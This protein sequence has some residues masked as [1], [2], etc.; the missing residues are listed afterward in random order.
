[1]K[2]SVVVPAFNEERL[3]AQSL[4]AINRARAAFDIAG[5]TSELI[6][7][8]N[9]STDR[10]AE[11]ARTAGATVVFEP[12]NQ[13]GRA[14][15]TGAAA[16]SGE[17]L[18]F[19]DADSQPSPELFADVAEQ[20][21]SGRCVAGGC[22]LRLEGNHRLANFVTR[23]WNWKSRQRRWLAG[24]FIFVEAAAFRTLGGFDAEFFVGEELDL[25]RRLH[26]FARDS[27]REIVILHRHP[28]LTSDRKVRLYSMKELAGFTFRAVLRRERVMRD[29]SA[30][31][32]WYDGR[33]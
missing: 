28:L 3:L 30:C 17:W 23:V 1:M 25:T 20:I 11:I 24:S 19:I 29:K 12:V 9:N 18:L 15:N 22:T 2:I 26:A 6:V 32:A 8:D 16:A 31:Y 4:A 27:K 33:R 13:I 14:R 5:Y 10:T 7:C 21:K